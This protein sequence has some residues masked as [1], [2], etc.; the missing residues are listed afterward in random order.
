MITTN[1]VIAIDSAVSQLETNRRA[2]AILKDERRQLEQTIID[3]LD[4]AGTDSYQTSGGV[5]VRV[6]NRPRRTFDLSVLASLLPPTVV[7]TLIRQDVDHSALDAAVAT[8]IVPAEVAGKATEVS[9]SQQVRLYGARGL[10][11]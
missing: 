5:R 9:Y 2:L 8:G 11:S 7:A 4:R 10:A 1:G 3:L 6:E